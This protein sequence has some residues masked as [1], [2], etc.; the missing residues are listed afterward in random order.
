MAIGDIVNSTS[1]TATELVTQLGQIGLWLQAIGL[2]VVIWIIVQII[3]WILN[4]KR[5][6]Q[7]YEI[8]EDMIRI[9]KKIDKIAK[10]I[11]K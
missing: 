9:E 5:M 7:V 4:R 8:R 11:N 10:S 2:I 6:K 1:E 3:N